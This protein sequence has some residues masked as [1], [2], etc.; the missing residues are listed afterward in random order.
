MLNQRKND[1]RRSLEAAQLSLLNKTI[2]TQAAR[3]KELESNVVTDNSK[4]L[5]NALEKIDE[6]DM[7]LSERILMDDMDIKWL[8]E[9]GMWDVYIGKPDVIKIVNRIKALESLLARSGDCIWLVREII[10]D[11]V[12][13]SVALAEELDSVVLDIDAILPKT[14]EVK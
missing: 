11:R 2:E 1:E 12:D 9:I 10:K 8:R 5:A 3:I 7:Q 6:L 14:E 4:A 13:F